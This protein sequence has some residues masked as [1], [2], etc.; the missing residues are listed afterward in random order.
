[1]SRTWLFAAG[2]ACYFFFVFWLLTESLTAAGP[3]SFRPRYLSLES[4]LER[5]NCQQPNLVFLIDE[6]MART[7]SY[8]CQ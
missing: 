1:M 2:P 7:A 4:D 6:P 5:S 8:A 3:D